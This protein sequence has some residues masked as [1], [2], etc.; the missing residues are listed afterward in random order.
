MGPGYDTCVLPVL[1]GTVAGGDGPFAVTSGA[2][3]M[4]D[5]LGNDTDRDGD[6]DPTSVLIVAGPS[7]GTVDV[8]P[9][10]GEVT[11]SPASSYTGTDSFT[12]KVCDVDGNCDTATVTV[13]VGVVAA[14][15]V[16][17][18]RSLAVTGAD[19]GQP[20]ILATLLFLTGLLLVRKRRR[21]IPGS[22]PRVDR[23]TTNEAISRDECRL[24]DLKWGRIA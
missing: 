21:S 11:Y 23:F 18:G 12:D 9:D 17:A 5:V 16:D 2:A 1:S 13:K 22:R 24:R 6:R 8:D 10:T 14:P 7:H 15:P 4:V 19:P 3:R 20:I